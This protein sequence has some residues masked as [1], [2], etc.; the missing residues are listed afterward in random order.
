MSKRDA[1]K[2]RFW[3]KVIGEQ[4]KSGQTV[5]AFCARESMSVHKFYW[6]KRTL[7][8][9]GQQPTSAT[10]ECREQE[11]E[12]V[13]QTLIPVRLPSLTQAPIELVHPSGWVVRVSVGFDPSTLETIVAA[14]DP[15]DRG[16]G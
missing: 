12:Q 3:K 11:I 16:E 10:G 7:R 1:S 4:R 2:E 6:W 8:D 13:A 9:R 14:F 15:S 5:V